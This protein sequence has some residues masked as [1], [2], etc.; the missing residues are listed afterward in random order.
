M[1]CSDLTKPEES[2]KQAMLH[3]RVS[4]SETFFSEVLC[5]P[6]VSSSVRYP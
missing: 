1:L 4:T 3:T 5:I 2:R 6:V